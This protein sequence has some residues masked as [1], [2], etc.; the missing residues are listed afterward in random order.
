V[1]ADV[2]ASPTFLAAGLLVIAGA[3]KIASPGASAQ[4]LSDVRIPGGRR[5]ARFLGALEVLAAG[6]ACLA[7]E[8]GGA[9]ALACA[10]LGFSA[11][12]AYLLVAR[13]DAGSCGCAGAKAVPPSV[14]HLALDALAG[15]AALGY[16]LLHG[17][18]ARSW[19]AS[20]GMG[21]LPVLGGL[22]LAGWIAAI[23]VA[24]APRSWRSWVPDPDADHDHGRHDHPRTDEALAM[25][26]IGPG[27]PSL[28]PNTADPPAEW[29]A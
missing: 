18:N 27:D 5:S 13:P 21:A 1:T 16:A 4:L 7:P 11:F 25:A 14:L 8:A 20:L 29:T 19:V 10:Y 22:A 3:A 26:G 9:Y 23:A 2:L 28:W 24:E 15:S 17:P 12:L 6:W